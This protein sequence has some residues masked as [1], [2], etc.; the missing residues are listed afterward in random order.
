MAGGVINPSSVEVRLARFWPQRTE[1]QCHLS[2]DPGAAGAGHHGDD[3]DRSHLQYWLTPHIPPGTP[4]GDYRGLV[5]YQPE[6]AQASQLKLLVKVLLFRLG[7]RPRTWGLYA[8]GAVGG[9]TDA[10]IERGCAT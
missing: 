9:A 10:S 7:G 5:T 3:P 6:N 4:A 2:P 1:D 8:D